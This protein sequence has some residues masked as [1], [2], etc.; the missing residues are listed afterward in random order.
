MNFTDADRIFFQSLKELRVAEKIDP[1]QLEEEGVI[2]GCGD[3]DRVH[4]L[5][6]FHRTS[7]LKEGREPRL[8]LVM[9]NGGPLNFAW[10]WPWWAVW[11]WLQ[12]PAFAVKRRFLLEQVRGA[13]LL[14][15]LHHIVPTPHWPCGQGQLWGLDLEGAFDLARRAESFL[16][17]KFPANKVLVRLHTDKGGLEKNTYHICVGRWKATARRTFFRF[18][19]NRA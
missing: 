17:R 13:I 16:K 14:K 3:C 7:I 12:W 15:G 1:R 4:E 2:I 5:L 9:V 19:E 18:L 8:H 11:R 6:D 10:R